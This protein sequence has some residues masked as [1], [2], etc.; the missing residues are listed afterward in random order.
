[1]EVNKVTVFSNYN[2][3]TTRLTHAIFDQQFISVVVVIQ[4][5]SAGENP[6]A[7]AIA[8]EPEKEKQ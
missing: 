1:M 2:Y 4:C 7:I 3:L 8:P 5:I 6:A